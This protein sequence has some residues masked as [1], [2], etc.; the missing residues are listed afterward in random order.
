MDPKNS[1]P[2]MQ[3]NSNEHEWTCGCQTSY[4]ILCSQSPGTYWDVATRHAGVLRFAALK[5]EFK[6]RL[7]YLA[8]CGSSL[9]GPVNPQGLKGETGTHDTLALKL[10]PHDTPLPIPC[11][12]W[13]FCRATRPMPNQPRSKRPFMSRFSA[14]FT[15]PTTR[16]APSSPPDD[17]TTQGFAAVQTGAY[18][19]SEQ[20]WLTNL[21]EMLMES[22]GCPF[23]SIS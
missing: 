14:E 16:L 13:D 20:D 17:G 11:C 10:I 9:S 2:H 3:F 6:E 4:K 12:L 18:I 5:A 7:T 23:H 19:V 1:Q 15:D 22:H 21:S 8:I